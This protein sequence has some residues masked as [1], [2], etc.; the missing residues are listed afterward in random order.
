MEIATQV[1]AFLD[2]FKIKLNFWGLILRS[3][4][5]KNTQ[6]LADLGL[7]FE[8]VKAILADLQVDEYSEGPLPDRMF[9][10]SEMWVFGR[11]INREEVYIKITLGNFNDKVICI[12]FHFAERPMRYPLRP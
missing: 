12:S 3:D 2:S 11:I 10:G 8:G 9:G 6:T 1:E 7:R 4:R 5:R